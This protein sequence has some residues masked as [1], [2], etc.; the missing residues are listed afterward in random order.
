L[1]ATA[2]HHNLTLVTRNTKDMAGTGAVLSIHGQTKAIVCGGRQEA[3]RRLPTADSHH[4]Q[5]QPLTH[6][7]PLPDFLPAARPHQEGLLHSKFG[8][9]EPEIWRPIGADKCS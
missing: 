4:Y 7:N 6:T 2:I 5:I 8:A 1:A 9:R 3:M